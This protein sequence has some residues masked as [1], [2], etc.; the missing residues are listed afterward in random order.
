[1]DQGFIDILKKV[2]DKHGIEY[3]MDTAKCKAIVS[4]YTGSDY[5]NER[6]LLLR[7]V[8]AGVSNAI[9]A[10]EKNNLESC[11]KVQ[12]REL[13]EEQFMDT[14]IAWNIVYVI[15]HVLHGVDIKEIHTIKN[16]N[17][18]EYDDTV[19]LF[20]DQQYEK[21]IP[22]LELL[23][24]ENHAGAQIY[25]SRAYFFG[26]GVT[27][28]EA[29]G[30]E[31]LQK[32]ADQGN[33]GAQTELGNLYNYFISGITSE[34][35]YTKTFKY[36]LKAAEQGH[37]G[38]LVGL[39]RCYLDGIGVTKNEVKAIECFRKAADQG[40]T[41]A[42][43][44]LGECYEEGKGVTQDYEKS[45]NF[46]FKAV[47]KGSL[48]AQLKLGDCYAYGKGTAKDYVKAAELYCSV[49]E[50]GRRI[51][52][53]QAQEKLDKLKEL[54][55][56]SI[57][58]NIEKTDYEK[59]YSD[60]LIHIKSKRYKEGLEIIFPLAEQGYSRA[61]GNLGFCYENG[62]GVPQD[63]VKAAE[64]YRKAADQ[65]DPVS[66][67]NLGKLKENGKICT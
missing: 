50:K 55:K 60:A 43:Q 3:F 19:S 44:Q 12:Q 5:R 38:G 53:D 21:S 29:K 22:I 63:Y 37:A 61:Q 46:Y 8:E 11:M 7:A 26:N 23:A 24:K 1:M 56:I 20:L 48:I 13:H 35:K 30:I 15:A 31:W 58:V 66:E 16:E 59:K 6:G 4:D 64:W 67:F 57:G 28:D 14:D 33:A 51:H 65:G 2:V 27:K 49:L 42:Q 54:E 39:A 9:F 25:I 41:G 34:E 18:S 40:H 62:N 32:A 45:F 52:K 36:Y 47:E 10:V 17:G